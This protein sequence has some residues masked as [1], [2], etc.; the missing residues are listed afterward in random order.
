VASTLLSVAVCAT[1]CIVQ[2]TPFWEEHGVKVI[3]L[4]CDNA[5]SHRAWL[6]DIAAFSGVPITY[7]IIADEDR[8]VKGDGDHAPMLASSR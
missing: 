4:S 3:A 2:L 8:C 1:Q 5:D 7:P 6:A